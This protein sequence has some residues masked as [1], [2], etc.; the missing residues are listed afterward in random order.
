MYRLFFFFV[1]LL[2]QCLTAQV[3]GE[4]HFKNGDLVFQDLDC[5]ELCDAIE[6][7]TPSFKDKH[8]SHIGLV[9]V[10]N[11]SV[12]IIE[13]IGKDVH[14][15]PIDLFLERQ[16][17]MNHHPQVI[18]ERLKPPFQYLINKA[19][20]QALLS[21]GIPYDDY[22]L[23]GNGKLYCSELIFEAFKY[24]NGGDAFFH[25]APMTFK[26]PDTHKFFKAWKDYYKALKTKIP[27]G[28]LGCNPGSIANSPY[29]DFI[30]SF[31]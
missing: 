9:L 6:K 18:V 29:L 13:A 8:F 1:L 26:D 16:K 22:F 5:G 2:P 17:N 23:N 12:L 10:Q 24:A 25:M 11:D 30:Y 14:L 28:K 20:R 3:G 27:E 31:Y 7:V 4:F 15:T 19:V 21:K